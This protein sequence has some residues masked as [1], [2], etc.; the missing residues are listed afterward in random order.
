MTASR[1][2]CGLSTL[3]LPFFFGKAHSSF[4]E[5]LRELVLQE[6]APDEEREARVTHSHES[7]GDRCRALAKTLA[8]RR[9]LGACVPPAQGGLVFGQRDEE[10]DVRALCIAREVLAWG[11]GLAEYVFAMQGLGSYPI[12][13]AGTEAQRAEYL[14][15][16]LRGEHLAAFA[17]TEPEAGSDVASLRTMAVR[18]GEEW[19]LSG[20]KTL[21]SNAGIADHYVVFART[22][23]EPGSRSLS[24]FLVRPTDP[25]FHFVESLPVSAEH[26]L[27][28]LRFEQLRLPAERLLGE[29]GQGFKIAMATLDTFRSTVGAASLGMARRALDEALARVCERKQFGQALSEFQNTRSYLAEMA[30]TL[31]ASRLLVYRA[32]WT[33]DRGAERVTLEA[34]M[35]KLFSTEGAQ[36]V[37][38]RAVQLFGGQGVLRGC[39]VERLYR[40]VRA[41]RIY[42]GT[43]EIQR[44]VIGAQLVAGE[45]ARRQEHG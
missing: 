5:A 12:V 7:L 30:T 9:V 37:I 16:V 2:R 10:V 36:T 27:G 41:L 43:S 44:L 34:A 21:I 29:P 19:V 4:A 25:G 22:A 14:A 40:E 42:E 15:P 32:A 8:E 33:R 6:L 13:Y 28:S 31:D 1:D 20:E 18:D 38:D 26:P 39:V 3:D 35:A 24:A 17:I 23:P 11:S 45:R